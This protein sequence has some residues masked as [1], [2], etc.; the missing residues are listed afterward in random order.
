MSLHN[1]IESCVNPGSRQNA[2]SKKKN[3]R[4]YRKPNSNPVSKLYSD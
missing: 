3:I 1:R 4:L 2:L